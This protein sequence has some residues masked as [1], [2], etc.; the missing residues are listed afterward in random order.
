MF[1]RRPCSDRKR[2][3]DVSDGREAGIAGPA[4]EEWTGVWLHV[5][6][7]CRLYKFGVVGFR[8]A[9]VWDGVVGGEPGEVVLDEFSPGTG[10]Q[11]AIK[12]AN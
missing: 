7:P 9:V 10:F 12:I 1:V 3:L 6:L 11:R 2:V 8:D 5:R 4:F